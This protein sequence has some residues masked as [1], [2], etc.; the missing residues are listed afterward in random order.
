MR[1]AI[2]SSSSGS[3]LRGI[4]KKQNS[5]QISPAQV[6]ATVSYKKFSGSLEVAREYGCEAIFISPENLSRQEFDAHLALTLKNRKID[7]VVLA[8]WMKILTNNFLV[9][10]PNKVINI[11]PALLPKH[12]GLIDLNV[13]KSVIKAKDKK[14]GITIH[15]VTPQVDAGPILLQKKVKVLTNDTPEKLRA[16]V[17][18]LERKWYPLVIR[19]FEKLFSAAKL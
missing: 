18:S 10:F 3:T 5:G 1:I 4:M 15:L 16:K 19:D 7:L 14:S 8:G 12:A 11:H 2:L 9:H 13:H 6:V 17:Q